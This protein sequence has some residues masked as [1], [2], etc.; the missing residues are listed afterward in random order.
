MNSSVSDVFLLNILYSFECSY[1][2]LSCF[3]RASLEESE[4]VHWIFTNNQ[5]VRESG[6]SVTISSRYRETTIAVYYFMVN[7]IEFYCFLIL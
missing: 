3:E 2:E 1:L 4:S 7:V 6:I 5:G